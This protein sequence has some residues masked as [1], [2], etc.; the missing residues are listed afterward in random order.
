M[1]DCEY[2]DLT[3]EQTLAAIVDALYGYALMDA[4]EAQTLLFDHEDMEG[5][6]ILV[7]AMCRAREITEQ[8]TQIANDAAQ[9]AAE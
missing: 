6:F 2:H 9:Q 1:S 8:M 5:W 7:S 3:A 4:L